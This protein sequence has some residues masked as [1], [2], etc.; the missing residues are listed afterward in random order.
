MASPILYYLRNRSVAEWMIYRFLISDLAGITACLCLCASYLTARMTSIALG[1]ESAG[2]RSRLTSWL[3][4]T[5]WFWAVPI[6]F[7]LVGGSLVLT[8][9]LD[10][11]TTGMTY[12]HWSRYVVMSFCFAVAIILSVTRVIDY[13]LNL[14]ASRL[15]YL[16]TQR[17]ESPMAL[18]AT[19]GENPHA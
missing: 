11:L 16:K 12:E 15:E 8:S 3:F 14:V 7:W 5:R 10:R 9:L 2:A 6:G 4:Q 18:H 13:V 1:E 17:L 19:S